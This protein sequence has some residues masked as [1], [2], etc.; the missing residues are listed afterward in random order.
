MLS[1][2]V[3]TSSDGLLTAMLDN[4][5]GEIGRIALFRM[6]NLENPVVTKKAIEMTVE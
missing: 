4:T 3:A 1:V 2:Q 6:E 5:S